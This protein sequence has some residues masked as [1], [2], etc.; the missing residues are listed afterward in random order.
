MR[1]WSV[2][3]ASPVKPQAGVRSLPG[4]AGVDLT[5]GLAGGVVSSS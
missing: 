2:A 1:H 5:T 4:D 3:P